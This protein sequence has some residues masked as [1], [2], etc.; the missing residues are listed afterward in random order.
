MPD[1][2]RRAGSGAILKA[3][4]PGRCHMVRLG[5]PKGRSMRSVKTPGND[6]IFVVP[7][8]FSLCSARAIQFN[9]TAARPSGKGPTTNPAAGV[10]VKKVVETPSGPAKQAKSRVQPSNLIV[11]EISPAQVAA[12]GC[13]GG[14]GQLDLTSFCRFSW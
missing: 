11:R 10:T 13:D 12:P 1:L 2:F 7:L 6:V 9:E 4:I 14:Q 3:V 8:A 5:A